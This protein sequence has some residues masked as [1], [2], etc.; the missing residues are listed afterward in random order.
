MNNNNEQ[1]MFLCKIL[2]FE[3]SFL[4]FFFKSLF[5]KFFSLPLL[6]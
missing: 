3:I 6:K 1:N 5:L 2:K 4:T